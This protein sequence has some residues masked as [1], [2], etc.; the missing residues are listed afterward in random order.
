MRAPTTLADAFGEGLHREKRLFSERE[1]WTSKDWWDRK[2]FLD[3]MMEGEDDRLEQARLQGR[4]MA[5]CAF[6]HTRYGT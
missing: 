2:Q 5:V 6:G 4:L 3:D 1:H